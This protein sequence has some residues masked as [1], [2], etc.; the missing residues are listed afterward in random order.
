MA[1]QER[2]RDARVVCV[3]PDWCTGVAA[4]RS[5][6]HPGPESEEF[7][8]HTRAAHE[9]ASRAHVL[10]PLEA[11]SRQAGPLGAFDHE[12]QLGSVCDRRV[13]GPRRVPVVTAL[14][15]HVVA[16]LVGCGQRLHRRA[17]HEGVHVRDY[18]RALLPADQLVLRRLLHH[19][20]VEHVQARRPVPH[21]APPREGALRAQRP[22]RAALQ[23][24][25]HVA[26][27]QLALPA[28]VLLCRQ[29]ELLRAE[30]AKGHER[31]PVPPVGHE[32]LPPTPEALALLAHPVE[33]HLKR[34]ELAADLVIL[35]LHLEV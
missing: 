24:G 26:C 25:F 31:Q 16:L 33:H 6:A 32:Q 21:G 4:R 13:V 22:R 34:V 1:R 18:P 14:G 5:R 20:G 7:V 28:Q 8:H 27:G 2:S 11:N 19:V 29:R 35:L 12:A 15:D 9:R 17:Q 3:L 30:L 23:V 10:H